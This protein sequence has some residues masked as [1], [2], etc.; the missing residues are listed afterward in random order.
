MSTSTPPLP[1][2]WTKGAYHISTDSSLIPLETFNEWLASDDFYWA[3]ALP[4]DVLKQTLENCLCFGLYYTPEQ[5]EESAV[6]PTADFIGIARCITDYTTFIYIT[7]V[8]VHSS[9][10]GQ[11]LGSWLMDCVGEVID[12]MPYLRRSMLFTMDWARSVPFYE[13]ILG[14]SVTESK[15]GEG[16]AMMMR[17]GRGYPQTMAG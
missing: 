1:K 4:L 10:Q 9:H 2:T 16:M 13:K 3:G 15:S 6:K 14:M 11:G 17:K 8:Y 12:A 7:D 5:Q